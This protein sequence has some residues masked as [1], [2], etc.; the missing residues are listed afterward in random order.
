MQHTGADAEGEF[1]TEVG[2]I[3]SVGGQLLLTAAIT[4]EL[5][6]HEVQISKHLEDWN[7]VSGWHQYNLQRKTFL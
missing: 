2:V 1:F 7:T 4:Q 6:L 3:G 5:V